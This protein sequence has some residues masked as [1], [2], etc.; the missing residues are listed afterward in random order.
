MAKI[1][2][3]FI[4][5]GYSLALSTDGSS[6]GQYVQFAPGAQYIPVT[7]N[8]SSSYVVGPFNDPRTYNIVSDAGEITIGALTASG[9]YTAQDVADLAATYHP[10]VDSIEVCSAD[11]AIA[12]LH[13]IVKITKSASAAAL[14]L[15]APIDVTDDGKY[16][17]VLSTTAKAHVITATG[18]IM[19][20]TAGS[21]LN[22]ITFAAYPGA[23][24][25]LMAM[26]GYW[27]AIANRACTVA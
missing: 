23:G 17:N 4:P 14:T 7:I 8:V 12:S 9:S 3:V 21:P 25:T 11:G 1:A 26:G 22:S 10:L 6:S 16:I 5:A 27:Y 20:G 18:L 24:V 2:S 15:A 19:N 13:G